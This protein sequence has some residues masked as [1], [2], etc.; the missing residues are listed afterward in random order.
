MGHGIKRNS[1][2]AAK[3]LI[4]LGLS[5]ASTVASAALIPQTVKIA[6]ISGP[7]VVGQ[8]VQLRIA[9]QGGSTNVPKWSLN[10]NIYIDYSKFCTFAVDPI[11]NI[12]TVSLNHTGGCVM[13]AQQAGNGFYEQ[14]P[15][16]YVPVTDGSY[17]G[18]SIPIA[19]APVEISAQNLPTNIEIG[20][21][22]APLQM[23]VTYKSGVAQTVTTV[24]NASN[25]LDVGAVTTNTCAVLGN[26]NN[27]TVVGR[28]SGV[29][30]I[31]A[32][33]NSGPTFRDYAI[34][35]QEFSINVSLKPQ[36]V[37]FPVIGAGV[38]NR[39]LPLAATSSLGAAYPITFSSQ[40]SN[41]CSVSGSTLT[42]WNPGSC[43]VTASQAGDANYAPASAQ[44]LLNVTGPGVTTSSVSSSA[45][46]ATSV[47]FSAKVVSAVA[48]YTPTGN[49]SFLS[50]GQAIAGCQ[51][52]PL[53]NNATALCSTSSLAKG[54]RTIHVNYLGDSNNQPSQ[55]QPFSQ[56]I[57]EV[58]TISFTN[59][60]ET[61]NIGNV[62][63]VAATSS[64]ALTP[65]TISSLTPTACL[66]T[67]ST[68]NNVLTYSVTIKA[69]TPLCEVAA[70]Q[71]AG[72]G[73]GAAQ[74]T[75]M[76]IFVN[77]AQQSINF[78][79]FPLT[80]VAQ[81]SV[82]LGAPAASATSGLPLTYAVTSAI[83]AGNCVI[84][85]T[86]TG[87][88]F[89]K[90]GVCAITAS[91]SG[92]GD[93]A[94][95]NP[96]TQNLTI[97]TGTSITVSSSGSPASNPV[98]TATVTPVVAGPALSGTISFYADN[99]STPICTANLAMP[100]CSVSGLSLGAHQL[101]AVYNGDDYHLA[102][103]SGNLQQF[104]LGVPTLAFAEPLPS[105]TL[106]DSATI[107][108]SSNNTATPVTIKSNTPAVCA[109]TSATVNNVVTYTVTAKEVTNSQVF[110]QVQADQVA[111]SNYV[112]ANLIQ[113]LN[114]L[115][116]ASTTTLA[117]SSNPVMVRQAVTFTAT[118]VGKS[119][120]GSV[121][122]LADGL[123]IA[124]CNTVA[125]ANGSA[126]CTTSALKPGTR[127]IV[128]SYGG[129]AKNQSSQ[130]APFEQ[131]IT[132]LDWLPAILNLLLSN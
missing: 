118:V 28:E 111:D 16:A 31:R 81:G 2:W 115:E 4:G 55:S 120:T 100:T 33:F 129:D 83:P 39:S 94:P 77:R 44:Q 53:L 114:I 54:I 40:P 63:L 78:S 95:A 90:P 5:L 61:Q 72:N 52:V 50:D 19:A 107:A 11:S 32:T 57:L 88:S 13:V 14:S 122:F 1:N 98:L 7:F 128:A 82:A 68:L 123:A 74:Q 25:V 102:S 36:T 22:S 105:L 67:S 113:N 132:S 21:T 27:Y 34:K 85:A 87:V 116:T 42:L 124:N 108:A 84:N 64:N 103:T 76:K 60:L 49:V 41:V 126:V 109:V 127:Q 97:F 37:N 65:V 51:N 91:Q 38:T 71:V 73:F 117:S 70:N 92:N 23:V 59:Q 30:K 48:G 80:Q 110:C 96:V 89:T 131:K 6:P 58:P 86:N 125:L 29:C 35:E 17:T 101:K 75:T 45:N 47:T 43:T 104:I 26:R 12:A 20:A 121:S 9:S 66:V 112:D 99:A 106:G 3:V 79:A 18:I 119:P 69:A 130:S 24:A 62:A 93:Y 46:P 56:T 10:Q 15:F 8:V